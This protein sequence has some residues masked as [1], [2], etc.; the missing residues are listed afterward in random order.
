MSAMI[1]LRTV[2][3]RYNSRRGSVLSLDRVSLD[4][5]QGE[6]DEALPMFQRLLDTQRRLRGPEHPRALRA[7]QDLGYLYSMKGDLDHAVSTAS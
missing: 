3:K 7:L 6:F 1:S 4:I 2:T 5:E